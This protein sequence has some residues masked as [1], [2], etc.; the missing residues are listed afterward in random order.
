MNDSLPSLCVVLAV[1]SDT[2]LLHLGGIP[3]LVRSC[4]ILDTSLPSHA[5][6][7]AVSP[8]HASRV[9]TLLDARADRYEFIICQPSEPQS[10][11]EALELRY[12]TVDAVMIHDA[13]RPLTP[14]AQF[15]GVLAALKDDTD[16]VRPAV[17]FTETLKI[18]GQ[19]AIIKETLDRSTVLR[20]STPELIRVTAIDRDG[21]DCGWF[22]P[23]KEGARTVH[24]EGSPEGSRINTPADRDLM[25]LHQN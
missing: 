12:G 13:S 6:F 16:A 15:E 8:E 1:T 24:I 14:D 3:I 17:P 10:L 20:I 2:A 21:P 19:D 23:L 5:V 22:L 11:A 4:N 25:E 9:R 18:L 7:I